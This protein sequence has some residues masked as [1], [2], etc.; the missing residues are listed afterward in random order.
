[1]ILIARKSAKFNSKKQEKRVAK[2]IDGK[3]TLNSGA[4]YFQKGDVRN[5]KY[6]IE[7]KTTKKAFYTM[8]VDVWEKIEREAVSDGLRIPIMQVDL[9]DG[10]QRYAVIEHADYKEL[11]EGTYKD[12]ITFAKSF[13][14]KAQDE[15]SLVK[16][17]DAYGAYLSLCVIPW[18]DFIDFIEKG[19]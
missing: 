3:T 13:R 8:E 16:F 11:K 2:E 1:M 6:L 18:S 7:C 15:I 19:E 12:I 5:E 14:L 17:Y 9:L 10:K 4:L